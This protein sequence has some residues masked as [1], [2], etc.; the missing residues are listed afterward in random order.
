MRRR[1]PVTSR[2]AI[3]AAVGV[4][5]IVAAVLETL[6]R[7]NPTVESARLY[8]SAHCLNDA[9]LGLCPNVQSTFPRPD[10]R[11]WELST[12]EAGER[13]TP[14][15]LPGIAPPEPDAKK[16]ETWFIGDSISMGY[17]LDD[18][19]TPPWVFE[20][21]SGR[22]TRNLASDSLGT[23]GIR[24]RLE[25][26][27]ARYRGVTVEHLFWIYNTSDFTDDRKELRLRSSALYRTAYRL[28]FTLS[29]HS[30]AY[31]RLRTHGADSNALPPGFDAAPSPDHPT[32]AALRDLRD[33]VHERGLP[34]T[35]LVYPGYDPRSHG[36]AT[37]D[38]TT[39]ALLDFLHR[40]G[41][42]V[43]DLSPAFEEAFRDGRRVYVEG[44]GHPDEDMSLVF[45][46]H[47][48]DALRP[49]GAQN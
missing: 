24:S 44:D 42:D 11:T 28:H 49:S 15:T 8:R 18:R 12:N 5:L 26:A 6:M 37:A 14:S 7:R 48:L 29:Q 43:R 47:A 17:L 33:T 1:L 41:F 40:E 13:I 30:A 31:V 3:A 23:L 22:S 2:I 4:L 45:A 25:E 32:W 20:E 36:P 38:P 34:L 35:V 46:A 39:R 27:L 9:R 16:K 21:L 10:G 19:F